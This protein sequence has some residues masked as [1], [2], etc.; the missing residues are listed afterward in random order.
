L[1]EKLAFLK[2]SIRHDQLLSQ[3]DEVM[4]GFELEILKERSSGLSGSWT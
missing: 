4:E 1:F 2:L 3:L